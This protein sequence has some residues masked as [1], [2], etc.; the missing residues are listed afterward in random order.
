VRDF[1]QGWI[2]RKLQGEPYRPLR[3]RTISHQ[4]HKLTGREL[5]G[6]VTL[7]VVPSEEFRFVD[8]A[9][10]PEQREVFSQCVLDGILDALLIDL[11]AP[12]GKATFVLEAI[13][14]R[15]GSSVPR[16]YGEAAREAV[17]ELFALNERERLGIGDEDAV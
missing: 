9:A 12:P 10:W 6:S 17:G 11:G 14:W 8:N 3:E 16:A 5:Y 13:E 1:L 4:W 7:H 15:K 2:S